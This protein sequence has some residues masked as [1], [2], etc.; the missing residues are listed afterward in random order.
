VVVQLWPHHAPERGFTEEALHEVPKLEA[1]GW[2][3][4]GL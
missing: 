1:P 3:E 4:D 2:G